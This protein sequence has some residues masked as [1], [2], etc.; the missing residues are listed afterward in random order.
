MS[1]WL[2]SLG[3][4]EQNLDEDWF[5]RD[6]REWFACPKRGRPSFH[7]GDRVLIY[8]TGHQRIVGAVEVTKEPRLDP[9]FVRK[10]GEFDGDRWPWVV[11]HVPLLI[12][13][14]VG[15]GPRLARADIDTLSVRSK[16]HIAITPQQYRKGVAGL[17]EAAGL[18]GETFAA[19]AD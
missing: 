11:E 12:V 5:V 4:S 2:K 8:A 13:P 14:R 7:V 18:P 9:D 15:R 1:F 17:A 3:V 6:R 10:E 19:L 16:S